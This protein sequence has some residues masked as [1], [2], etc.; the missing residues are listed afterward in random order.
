MNLCSRHIYRKEMKIKRIFQFLKR[1][2]LRCHSEACSSKNA[3][4]SNIVIFIFKYLV[5]YF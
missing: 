4:Y 2:V 1:V 3:H 5:I